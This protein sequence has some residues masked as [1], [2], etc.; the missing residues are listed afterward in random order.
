[1]ARKIVFG[2]V[3]VLGLGLL[4]LVSETASAADPVGTGAIMKK[5]HGKKGG[6][7]PQINELVKNDKL[8]DALPLAKQVADLTADL[9]KNKPKKGDQ[10]SW[11]ELTKAYADAGKDLVAAL[12]KKDG[13]AAKKALTTINT[14]CMACHKAHK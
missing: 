9:G 12:D 3:A 13:D 5:N 1:M 10:K 2:V 14:S 6:L 8:A 11:D 7:I 4:A